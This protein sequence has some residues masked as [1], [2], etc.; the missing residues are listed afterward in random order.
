MCSKLHMHRHHLTS[1]T[2]CR[3]L[4]PTRKVSDFQCRGR[5]RACIS[6]K[7]PV[8]AAATA[9]NSMQPIPGVESIP[10]DGCVKS[11][12]THPGV[13][14]RHRYGYKHR[15]TEAGRLPLFGGFPNLCTCSF[16]PP[17]LIYSFQ[18]K[19]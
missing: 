4:G 1:L 16:F 12:I 2:E 18:F 3:L 8:D 14:D 19:N 17:C 11:N 10:E 9:S 13:D 7:F 15:L 5:W 6:N